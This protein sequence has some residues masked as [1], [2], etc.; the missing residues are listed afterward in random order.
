MLAGDKREIM[1]GVINPSGIDYVRQICTFFS[2]W[3]ECGKL[4]RVHHYLGC[5]P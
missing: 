5:Q 4:L 3:L 1:V 2:I